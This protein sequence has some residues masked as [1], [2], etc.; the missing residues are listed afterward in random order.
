ML[1]G[2]EHEWLDTSVDATQ[3]I[4]MNSAIKDAIERSQRHN[5]MVKVTVNCESITDALCGVDCETDYQRAADGSYD[6]CGRTDTTPANEPAWRINVTLSK[7]TLGADGC[8]IV[9]DSE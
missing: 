8:I 2:V 5:E 9:T 6:V 1:G 7:M 3:G 4:I